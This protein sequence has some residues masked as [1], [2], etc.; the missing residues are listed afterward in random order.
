[1][2]DT[3]KAARAAVARTCPECG[4]TFHTTH[5]TK[6]FCDPAHTLAYGN[7]EAVHGKAMASMEKAWRLKRGSGPVGKAAFQELC[8]ILDALN[9]ED[10]EEKRPPATVYVE[11]LLATG[12][13][14]RDR[15]DWQADAAWRH[16]A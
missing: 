9:A 2:T 5:P 7:R 6:R 14:F 1:M 13:T 3:K 11:S 12:Y 16:R 4:I 8:S 15:Q 10:R